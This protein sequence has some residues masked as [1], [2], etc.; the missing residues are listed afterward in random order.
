MKRK[1][2]FDDEEH[3]QKSSRVMLDTHDLETLLGV[4]FEFFTIEDML[5]LSHASRAFRNKIDENDYNLWTVKWR[6]IYG[7]HKTIS[8]SSKRFTNV[9]NLC[10]YVAAREEQRYLETRRGQKDEK[11][12]QSCLKAKKSLLASFKREDM[13]ADLAAATNYGKNIFFRFAILFDPFETSSLSLMLEVFPLHSDP[14]YPLRIAGRSIMGGMGGLRMGYVTTE[15]FGTIFAIDKEQGGQMIF[16]KEKAKKLMLA[17]IGKTK[18]VQDFQ[19]FGETLGFDPE[20]FYEEGDTDDEEESFYT[21]EPSI[22]WD[23]YNLAQSDNYVQEDL[24]MFL[25]PEQYGY[26]EDR[27][28]SDR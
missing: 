1:N 15:Q 23:N 14:M 8:S 28:D 5:A 3:V 12:A 26:D 20:L 11:I 25:H 16:D 9:K 10:V 21:Q 13:D 7:N 22:D 17:T 2:P 18:R 19:D 27:W 6:Q 24:E 4:A